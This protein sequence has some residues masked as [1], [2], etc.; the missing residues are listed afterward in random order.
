MSNVPNYGGTVSK[1]VK[2]VR[3]ARLDGDS[4][5]RTPYLQQLQSLTIDYS[6]VGPVSYNITSIQESEDSFLY[7]VNTQPTTSSISS[8]SRLV[9]FSPDAIDFEY[10][11]YNAVF[12]NAEI[13][14]F[15][16]Q[17]MDVDYATG[18]ITPQN[19]ELIISGTADPA[20]VQDSNYSSAA[21][22]NIRYNGSRVSSYDFNRPF[23]IR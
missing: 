23:V 11:D 22:S 4:I 16:T 18:M 20:Q 21:W 6:D 1:G 13:P 8:N 15:S 12:G 14:Q 3:I 2:Y 17:F 9:I 19:F 5:D 10:S 7:G